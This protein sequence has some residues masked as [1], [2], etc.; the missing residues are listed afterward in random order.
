MEDRIRDI[1]PLFSKR[2]GFDGWMIVKLHF[3]T[4]EKM[5][6]ETDKKTAVVLKKKKNYAILGLLWKQGLILMH[7]MMPQFLAENKSVVIW[8]DKTDDSFY[9]PESCKKVGSKVFSKED[10]LKFTE[11]IQDYN[12]IHQT[13]RPIV[14][15]FM[16]VEWIWE[17]ERI[18]LWDKVMIFRAPAYVQEGIELYIDSFSGCYFAIAKGA[19]RKNRLLWEVKAAENDYRRRNL[20][21]ESMFLKEQEVI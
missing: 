7:L 16:M 1:F 8:Q 11:E 14:P 20:W 5:A 13:E 18:S 19:G 12:W 2:K 6:S 17:I 15:G 9:L 4:R 10:V 21:K 3:Q